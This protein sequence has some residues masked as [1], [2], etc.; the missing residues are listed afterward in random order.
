MSGQISQREEEKEI[1]SISSP[2]GAIGLAN[3]T[4]LLRHV[5]SWKTGPKRKTMAPISP[6]NS[7]GFSILG[8]SESG[9]TT[10]LKGLKLAMEGSWTQ[11]EK[12][13]FSTVIWSN[14]VMGVRIVLEAMERMEIPL[15]DQRN[16]CHVVTIFTQQ[17]AAQTTPTSEVVDAILSLWRDDGFQSAY[18]QRSQY[19]L[20]DNMAYYAEDIQRLGV[21]EY[22]PTDED[23]LWAR[24]ESIGITETCFSDLTLLQGLRCSFLDVG[25]AKR[26]R[27][28]WIHAYPQ[29]SMVL[30]TVD[31]TAYGRVLF[32]CH[33][34]NRMS[35]QLAAFKTIVNS[36]WFTRT[37]FILIFTKLDLV[38]E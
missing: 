13:P 6:D 14:I 34:A 37:K 10:L 16:E 38:E 1:S 18:Q 15:D 12:L 11:E 21:P 19:Q 30:F 20:N 9:K 24:S 2:R 25:G 32:G 27:R 3:Q 36:G 35:E 33:H 28:K 7:Q 23:V 5:N 4:T 8:T 29:T 31:T 22:V 26:E 17:A